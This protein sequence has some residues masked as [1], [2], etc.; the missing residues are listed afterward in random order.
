MKNSKDLLSSVLKTTQMGQ[1]GIQAVQ[2]ANLGAHLQHALSTQL[3]EYDE[4]EKEARALASARNIRLEELSPTVK[5]MAKM[6]TRAR[7][8]YGKLDSK[9]AAMMIQ[10][11]TRGLIK[12][13]KNLH[14]YD[15]SDDQISGLSRKLIDREKG[16]IE[17]MQGFV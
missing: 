8:S 1:T 17:Q 12:G 4:L 10:G 16:N 14:S 3:K 9:A 15:R 6:M 11:N 2:K 5:T 13:L 7:L